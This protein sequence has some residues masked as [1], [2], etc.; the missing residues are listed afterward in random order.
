MKNL[1]PSAINDADFCHK[2]EI[3]IFD[4]FSGL[5]KGRK[6]LCKNKNVLICANIRKRPQVIMGKGKADYV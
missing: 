6:S 2:G 5:A 3:Y 1:L 4:K